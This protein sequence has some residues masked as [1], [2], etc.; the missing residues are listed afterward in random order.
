MKKFTD[1]PGLIRDIAYWINIYHT[2][3]RKDYLIYGIKEKRIPSDVLNEVINEL[4]E[5]SYEVYGTTFYVLPTVQ[6]DALY[7][8]WRNKMK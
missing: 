4:R 7:I 2:K 6:P 8:S 5:H 3:Y 1:K